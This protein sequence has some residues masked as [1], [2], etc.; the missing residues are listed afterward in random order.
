MRALFIAGLLTLN[1]VAAE[2]VLVVDRFDDDVQNQLGGYRN[3]FDAAPSHATILRDTTVRRGPVG[4]SLRITAVK[5]NEGFCGA[6][7]HLFDM[8]SDEPRYL[9]A[10]RFRFLSFWVKGSRGGERFKIKLADR[11]WVEKEDAL[12]LADVGRVLPRGVTTEWQE[13]IVPLDL[14]HTLSLSEL[15]GVTLEFSTPGEHTI[16]IDDLSFKK[17]PHQK[18]LLSSESE[19]PRQSPDQPRAMW[20]WKARSLLYDAEWRNELLDFCDA[21]NI[22]VLWVQLHYTLKRLDGGNVG[23]QL[24]RVTQLRRFLKN[25]HRRGISVHALDGDPS[26]CR[27]EL[28]HIPL[29]LIDAVLEF[30]NVGGDRERFDGIHLDNEPYLLPHWRDHE[31]REQLLKEY[32]ELNVECQ[33]RVRRQ[34]NVQFGVDLPFWWHHRDEHTGRAQADVSFHGKRQAASLHC[35]ELLD[36]VGIMNYRDRADGADGMITLGRDLL[37]FSDKVQ[38][39]DLYLGVET[40]AQRPVDV[41]FAFGIEKD[42]FHDKILKKHGVLFR[43]GRYE[44][45][46]IRTFDDGARIHVGLEMPADKD[47]S[48]KVVESMSS[49]TSILTTSI[50]LPDADTL[51]PQ[52]EKI[53]NSVLRQPQWK[54][55]ADHEIPAIRARDPWPGFSAQFVMLPKVTFADNSTADFHEQAKAADQYFERFATYRGLAIHYYTTF[56]RLLEEKR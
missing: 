7:I 47:L 40:F 43:S 46:R 41:W 1:V 54:H 30:N 25:A 6:W 8:N 14:G 11:R 35:I 13:V 49:I 33:R 29:S 52:M 27:R 12:E 34:K 18:T 31:L 5:K 9:N 38:G 56:R 20:V 22:G 55:F 3:S 28:H 39:A 42:Q 10:T 17:L 21:Q 45:C 15:G 19:F 44:G 50:E 53:R 2:R 36:N 51:R 4:R 48:E 32:L 26:Y 23:C 37:Q 24:Q 16:F